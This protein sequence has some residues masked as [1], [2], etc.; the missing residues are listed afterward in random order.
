[1]AA[2]SA[3]AGWLAWPAGVPVATAIAEVAPGDD[4]SPQAAS[5]VLDASGYVVARRQATVSAKITGKVVQVSI[6][7]GQRV[8]P[9]QVIAQARRHDTRR[10]PSRRPAPSAT[11]HSRICARREVAFDERE[12]DVSAQPAAVRCARSSARRRFDTAKSELRRRA[13]GPATSRRARSRSRRP[14]SRSPSAISTTR[15]CARRSPA[16]SRSRPRSQARWCRRSPPAAAS[17]AP[18]SAP[19]STWTRSRSRSTSARTSSTACIPASRRA[20]KLNAYPDWNIPARVIAIIPT[21]DRA[22]ATVKVRVGFEVK[23]PR[24]LPRD[25][26]A[27]RVSRATV[28]RAAPRAERCRTQRALLVPGGAVQAQRRHRRRVRRRTAT[29]SSGAPCAS[30]RAVARGSSRAVRAERRARGSRSAIRGAHRRRRR[31]ESRTECARDAIARGVR[32]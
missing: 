11:E 22:K 9:G 8:E 16:W 14:G 5:S 6:E 18:A 10:R 25:G 12:P 19:S 32:S 30:A 29:A 17:R 31:F 3:A 23:D 1:M 2:L 7:E 21:A 26:R 20:C 4:S 13:D 15:S 24:I 28:G 27:R